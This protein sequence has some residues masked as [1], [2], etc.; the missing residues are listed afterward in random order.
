M[1]CKTHAKAVPP[2]RAPRACRLEV[3]PFPALQDVL[4]AI[5]CSISAAF[6][7]CVCNEFPKGG[8][9][10]SNCFTGLK[11]T[12]IVDADVYTKAT[13]KKCSALTFSPDHPVNPEIALPPL[14]PVTFP[15]DVSSQGR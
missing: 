7:K 14:P 5:A 2:T 11:E 1:R 13:G 9:F 8:A 3:L 6:S 15:P 12:Q 4:N 10:A